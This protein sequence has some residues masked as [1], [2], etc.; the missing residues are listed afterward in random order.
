MGEIALVIQLELG[1]MANFTYIIADKNTREAAVIDPSDDT[2]AIL[3]AAKKENLTIIAV[4]LTHGH[5]DHVGGADKLA[6][7]LKIPV[8]LSKDEFFAYVPR[9]KNL[10]RTDEKTKIT[11]GNLNVEILSTPGH[12]PGCQSF[13]VEENLFTGD[14]LFVDAV[15]RTDFPGGSSATLFQSLARIKKLP[16]TTIIWPG[17]NY[18][19]V[20]HATLGVL[21]KENPFL[22]DQPD[23]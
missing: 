12:T 11:I 2:D 23:K 20:S 15:G 9:C 1:D 13:L 18:G 22:A 10:T 5:Y 19:A 8:Y 3:R 14:T 4:L 6:S 17:H 16:D 21:K 7:T